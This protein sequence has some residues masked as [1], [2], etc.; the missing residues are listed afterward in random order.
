MISKK[1]NI[2]FFGRKKRFCLI[3]SSLKKNSDSKYK[4]SNPHRLK[5]ILLV[6]L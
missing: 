1:L 5:N 2:K 3:K 4:Q 6:F